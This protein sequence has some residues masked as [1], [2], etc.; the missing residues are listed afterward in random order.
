MWGRRAS[1]RSRRLEVVGERENGRAP[2]F[3]CAPYFQA[4]AT[5][6]KGEH[7]FEQQMPSYLQIVSEKTLG[8]TIGWGHTVTSYMEPYLGFGQKKKKKENSP[9]PSN[10]QIKDGGGL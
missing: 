2:V 9:T 3:S 5:Q 7:L 4:P 8:T 6:A 10:T 1:L